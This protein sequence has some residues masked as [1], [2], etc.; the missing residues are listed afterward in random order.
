MSGTHYD[1]GDPRNRSQENRQGVLV[2]VES[3]LEEKVG[4]NIVIRL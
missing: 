1:V 4:Q 3:C 2:K